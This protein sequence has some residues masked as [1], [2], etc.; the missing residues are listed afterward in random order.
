M[1][2]VL[3]VHAQD[4]S[5]INEHIFPGKAPTMEERRAVLKGYEQGNYTTVEARTY[6]AI[7]EEET[8]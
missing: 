8:N 5:V 7:Q 6:A 3:K 1:I 2:Y 4:T